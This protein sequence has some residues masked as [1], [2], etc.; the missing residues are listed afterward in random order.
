[1]EWGRDI[2]QETG[3]T[4]IHMEKKCKKAATITS[5]VMTFQHGRGQR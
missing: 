2:V 5:M 1:M 3:I 4:T